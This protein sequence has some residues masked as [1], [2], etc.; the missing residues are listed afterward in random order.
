MF[1]TVAP[2]VLQSPWT[3]YF[4]QTNEDNKSKETY[5]S[6]I[7]KI[8]KFS[9]VEQFWNIFSHLKRP[10]ELEK[11]TELH[12]FR[13]DIRGMWE[14]GENLNGGKWFICLKKEFSSQLWELCVLAMIGEQMHPDILGA[15]VSVRNS[16][17]LSLWN[18]PV[19]NND[20]LLTIADSIISALSLPDGTIL[21][22]KRH[23]EPKSRARPLVV[24]VGSETS[25]KRKPARTGSART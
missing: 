3:L 10:S 20:L 8:A 15:V 2:H 11:A 6:T 21:R 25:K 14:D 24:Q 9:T 12:L 4:Q 23:E 22:Y 13:N 17:I 5:A 18:R 7:H 19:S 16:D 1:D